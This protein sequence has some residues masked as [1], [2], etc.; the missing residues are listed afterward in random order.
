MKWDNI[1]IL[2]NDPY[3]LSLDRVRRL[4]FD[5]VLTGDL[6]FSESESFFSDFSSP[7]DTSI[8]FVAFFTFDPEALSGVSSSSEELSFGF[9]FVFF[10]DPATPFLT[11]VFSSNFG[12]F[13]L[14]FLNFSMT[15]SLE[16][17]WPLLLPLP[18]RTRFG[19]LRT[20]EPPTFWLAASH[21]HL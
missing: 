9:F 10:W 7:S 17:L 14:F 8:N 2:L 11:G 20:L 3:S 21:K 6:S 1:Y 15:S 18:P 12:F 5:F 16:S 13:V 19:V 4:T